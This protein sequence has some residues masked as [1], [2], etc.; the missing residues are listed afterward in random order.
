MFSPILENIDVLRLIFQKLDF[1]TVSAIAPVCKTFATLSQEVYKNKLNED[2]IYPARSS[3]ENFH[4]SV[5]QDIINNQDGNMYSVLEIFETFI[6][7]FI[8][9]NYWI[10]FLY[11]LEFMEKFF[12]FVSNLNH[13]SEK[14]KDGIFFNTY[15]PNSAERKRLYFK[16]QHIYDILDDYFFVEYPDLYKRQDLLIMAQFKKLKKRHFM[17]RHSLIKALRRPENEVYYI[18]FNEKQ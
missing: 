15:A 13:I 18:N 5:I 16:L 4:K 11:D 14:Y 17:K 1:A 8:Q 10:L 3:Y 2:I 9:Y 6:T 12:L 7:S